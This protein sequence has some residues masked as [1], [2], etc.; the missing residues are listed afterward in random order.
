MARKKKKGQF[1]KAIVIGVILANV[2]FTIAVLLVFLKTSSEPSALIASWFAFTTVELWSL[3][4]IKT[5][6]ESKG[7]SNE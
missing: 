7:E 4:K 2:T 5:V 6:K 3:A 1:S